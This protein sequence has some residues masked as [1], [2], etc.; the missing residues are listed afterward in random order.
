MARYEAALRLRP[1]SADA[2]NNLGYALE[3]IP[4]RLDDAI[5]EYERALRLKPDDAGAQINLGNA[6]DAQGR[7]GEAVGHYETA[8]G[9]EPDNAAA[10]FNLAVA[11]LRIP[12]RGEEARAQLDEALRLDPRNVRARQIRDSLPAAQPKPPQ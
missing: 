1:D 2:H 3:R 11:L 9:L 12:G 5:A 6:L 10:H 4:G 7:T 8:L